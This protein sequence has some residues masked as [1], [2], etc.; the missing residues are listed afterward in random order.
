MFDTVIV[1]G[2]PIGS[3]IAGKL[4]LRGH[5][6]VVLEKKSTA[7]QETCCTGIISKEC[8]DLLQLNG[9]TKAMQVN[10][11]VMLSPSGRPL[12]FQ[13]K[14]EVAYVV[15][16]SSIDIEVADHAQKAGA[17]FRFSTHVTDIEVHPDY[18]RVKTNGNGQHHFLEARCAIIA[19][20]YGSVLSQKLNMGK[21][22]NCIIGVQAEVETCDSHEVEIYTDRN[23]APGGFAWLVPTSNCKS[24]A[25]LM[26]FDDQEEHL[27]YLLNTLKAEGKISSYDLSNS[28]GVIPL[29]PLP[30]TYS[31]RILVVGEAAGQVKPTTGGG[32]YFGI[33][34]AS[35]AVDVIHQ[36]IES[37]DYSTRYLSSYQKRWREKIGKELMIE[38]W[39]HKALTWLNNQ[40]IEYLFSVARKKKIQETIS[41]MENFSFDWHS[42]ILFHIAY[43]L[44][45]F[46]SSRKKM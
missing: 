19:T 18:I 30:R 14:D 12:Q 16:R 40:Q 29:R 39:S 45:P 38:Y 25:G 20:G 27:N 42:K 17:E 37:G 28:Y 35:I 11:A 9:T 32:I 5:K 26:T 44:L 3:Y 24:L 4:S 43:S 1:G 10:S 8:H 2:G 7:G 15:D 23:M 41:S 33:L 31:D 6:V 21:I 46:G 36:A 34:C 22:S 13:R